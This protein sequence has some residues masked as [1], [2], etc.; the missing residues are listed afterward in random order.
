MFD[1]ALTGGCI[2]SRRF[3]VCSDERFT[4][5]VEVIRASDVGFAHLE[6]TIAAGADDPEV[7]PAA[8]AGWTWIR[9]PPFFGEELKAAGFNLLS[10]A[11]NHTMDYM[12]GGLYATWA[13]LQRAGLAYAGSGRTLK[14]ARQPAFVD[15]PNG[16]A[17][18][19]S[20][21]TST[22]AWARAADPIRLD[23]GRPGANQMRMIQQVDRATADDLRG[24]AQRLGWWMWE[25]DDDIV[26]SPPGLHNTVTH[27]RVGPRC[28]MLADPEDVEA[29]LDAIRAARQKADFVMFHI[30][31]HEWDPAGGLSVPPT[32]IRD[33]AHRCVDAGADIVMAEGSHALLRGIEVY[34]GKA[35]FYDVGD[36]FKDGNAK[37]RPL[38]EYYW[39]QGRNTVTGKW[40]LTPETSR[41]HEDKKKLPPVSNPAGGYSSG[42]VVA[43]IVPVCRFDDAGKLVEIRI[44]P[45]K[46]LKDNAV[47]TGLP[48]LQTGTE[49]REIIDY[50]GELSEPFGTR[51]AFEDGVGV[52]RL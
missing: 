14:E 6:G 44:H 41:I 37:T 17:A 52:I 9:N 47:N 43:I 23:P 7:F 3:S 16:R 33:L 18:L 30:H 29:N 20:A 27:Y 12:Y 46:H 8:E 25:I 10:H 5:I 50:L 38:S 11:S 2:I 36:T 49:A 31:N 42:K 4:R 19:I 28:E 51:I 26:I 1:F 13:T 34:R 22:A 24:M 40:E 32:F 35:I 48:G 21:S 45:A 15:T 39:V